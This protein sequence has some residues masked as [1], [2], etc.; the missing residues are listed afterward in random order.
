VYILL[1]F[2]LLSLKARYGDEQSL[3]GELP[4]QRDN[5]FLVEKKPIEK[6]PPAQASRRNLSDPPVTIHGDP[7]ATRIQHQN[8]RRAPTT[9][10]SYH[11]QTR[12]QTIWADGKS[13]EATPL[14]SDQGEGG[15]VDVEAKPCCSPA[16][17]NRS[18]AVLVRSSS[19]L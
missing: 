6:Q 17:L 3:G 11:G 15:G 5:R 2:A 9:L 16:A 4:L 14:P 12:H 18:R 10:G 1:F 8:A 7:G 19:K 13:G